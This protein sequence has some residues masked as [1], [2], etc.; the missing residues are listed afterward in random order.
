MWTGWIFPSFTW[1]GTWDDVPIFS[2]GCGCWL[3]EQGHNQ[4]PDDWCDVLFGIIFGLLLLYSHPHC[5]IFSQHLLFEVIIHTVILIRAILW[6]N[7]LFYTEQKA[8]YGALFAAKLMEW[9]RTSL[10]QQGWNT[11]GT[12]LGTS[13]PTF[14]NGTFQPGDQRHGRTCHWKGAKQFPLRFGWIQRGGCWRCQGLDEDEDLDQDPCKSLHKHVSNILKLYQI[15]VV[16]VFFDS[17]F[18]TSAMV[19]SFVDSLWE[20]L[21]IQKPFDSGSYGHRPRNPYQAWIFPRWGGAT[22][23]IYGCYGWTSIISNKNIRYKTI[24]NM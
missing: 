24:W 23:V 5:L 11:S 9:I 22:G 12:A 8:C 18:G 15:M 13:T 2:V 7:R 16:E 20:G 4:A 19:K 3:R 14:V 1:P 21:C 6:G 10:F 17:F